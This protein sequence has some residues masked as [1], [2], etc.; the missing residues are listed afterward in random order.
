MDVD[1]DVAAVVVA[2]VGWQL[3]SIRGTNIDGREADESHGDRCRRGLRRGVGGEGC[4]VGNCEV[5]FA[6]WGWRQTVF[7][8]SL[9]G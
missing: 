7:R 8:T 5:Q 1:V 3:V 2:V 9:L 4:T 6:K